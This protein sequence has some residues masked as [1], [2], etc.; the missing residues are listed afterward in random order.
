MYYALSREGSV[1]RVAVSE[2]ARE[3]RLAALGSGSG[4]LHR[5]GGWRQHRKSRGSPLGTTVYLSTPR[6]ILSVIAFDIESEFSVVPVM[7]PNFI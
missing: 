3:L 6:Y 4:E 7:L 1:L 2:S 5:V